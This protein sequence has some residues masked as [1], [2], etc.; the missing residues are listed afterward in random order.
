M[1]S[2]LSGRHPKNK[3]FQEN[4]RSYNNDFQKTPF[5]AKQIVECQGYM[6]ALKI[7]G[8]IYHLARSLLSLEGEHKFLQ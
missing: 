3:K 4:I 1:F 6:P 8:Q 5:V 2:L 7:Q